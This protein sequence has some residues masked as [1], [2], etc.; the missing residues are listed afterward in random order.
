MNFYFCCNN[1]KG[2]KQHFYR[3]LRGKIKSRIFYVSM[4][5]MIMRN[6]FLNIQEPR[7]YTPHL[8]FFNKITKTCMITCCSLSPCIHLFFWLPGSDGKTQLLR[9]RQEEQILLHI[10][11]HSH[12]S[13]SI[14]ECSACWNELWHTTLNL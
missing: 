1:T 11:T 8:L 4:F 13:H 5:W 3:V 6:I 2:T 7:K 10:H 9:R 14:F 12:T